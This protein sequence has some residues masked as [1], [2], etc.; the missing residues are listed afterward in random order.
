[1]AVLEKRYPDLVP[2]YEGMFG[3]NSYPAPGYQAQLEK[4]VKE[5]CERHGVRYGILRCHSA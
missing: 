5:V 2:R 1:M 3:A 4:L